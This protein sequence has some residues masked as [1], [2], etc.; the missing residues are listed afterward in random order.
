M[1]ACYKIRCAVLFITLLVFVRGLVFAQNIDQQKSDIY[2]RLKCCSC[3]ELFSQ[4]SCPEAKEMKAYIDGLLESGLAKEEIFYRIAKKFSLKTII[5]AQT[6]QGVEKRL[7]QEAGQTRPQIVLGADYF[8]LGKV[9]KGKGKISKIFK[10]SNKGNS[11]LII[12][13]IKTTCPCASAALKVGKKKS[14]YFGTEGS[15]KD[16]Q[17]EIGPGQAGE[18]ELVVDFA[19]PHVKIGKLIREALVI[20]NDPIY[21]EVMVRIEAEVIE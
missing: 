1:K 7:I 2:S 6:K 17:E 21:S 20:S 13:N 11:A 8:D 18:L 15:P 10:I 3:E 4:C 16:W 19:S 14:P 5:D 12:K 9:S